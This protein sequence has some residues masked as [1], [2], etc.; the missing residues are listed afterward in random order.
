MA[1]TASEPWGGVGSLYGDHRVGESLVRSF[2]DGLELGQ[3]KVICV[4]NAN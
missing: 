2:R 4:A 3:A 1:Q